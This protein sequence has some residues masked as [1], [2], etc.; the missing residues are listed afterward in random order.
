MIHPY[1]RCV[2]SIASQCRIACRG[3]RLEYRLGLVGGR[4]GYKE[5]TKTAI[6][7]DRQNKNNKHLP[8]GSQGV[9]V[10]KLRNWKVELI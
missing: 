7:F 5:S 4:I 9:L 2:Y 8:R 1:P 3:D 6:P 10:L